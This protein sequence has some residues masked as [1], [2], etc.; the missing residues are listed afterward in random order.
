[1]VGEEGLAGDIGL[2]G[3]PGPMGAT[4]PAGPLGRKGDTG[5]EGKG[6]LISVSHLRTFFNIKTSGIFV[7]L[8]VKLPVFIQS[9][10]II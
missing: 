2:R 10:S 9:I 7:T 8:S 6:V 5:D 1:M 3:D 4:G